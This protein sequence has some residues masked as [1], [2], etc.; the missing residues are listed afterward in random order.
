MAQST[1]NVC[2][3]A[4]QRVGSSTILNLTDDTT[5]ARAC[6]LVYDSV[7]REQLRRYTWGFATSRAVLAPD[8]LAPTA[9]DDFPF[10]YQFTLPADCLRIIRP[11]R[12]ALDWKIEGRKL[13]TNDGTVLYLRYI[14]DITDAA[15]WDSSFY[16]VV[17]ARLAQRI[18]EKLT[19]SN[20]KRDVLAQ[21]YKEAVTAARLADAFESGPDD[22]PED[23]WLTARY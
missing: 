6:N 15:S 22:A 16:D 18:V 1:T 2:N 19:N 8:S 13:L 21:E 10:D 7:R 5:E 4:L 9:N 11:P 12:V 23:E 14:A 17:A 3:L 20:V